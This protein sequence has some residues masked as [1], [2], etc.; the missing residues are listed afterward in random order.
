MNQ[1]DKF[2][3]IAQNMDG[4]SIEQGLADGNGLALAINAE[5]GLMAMAYA[6]HEQANPKQALEILLDDMQLNLP[7]SENRD[8]NTDTVLATQCL[9]ESYENINEFLLDT[10]AR[11]G[12]S[13][14]LRPVAL[15]AIQFVNDK[16]SCAVVGDFCCLKF[17]DERINTLN[18]IYEVNLKG[19]S[20]LG[21]KSDFRVNM[22]QHGVKAGDFI[23]LTTL[24]VIHAV[25]EEHIRL[26]L[27][28]FHDNL[29]MALRQINTRAAKRGLEQKPAMI[30]ARAESPVVKKRGW[31]NKFR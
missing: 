14:Q 24:K 28:R 20:T 2:S 21:S 9:A 16:L 31:L 30:I 5:L 12:H 27:S 11:D 6:G 13:D 19:D 25:G 22:T 23:M 15:A 7:A 1:N 18:D 3:Y 10:F 17:S 26:T 8:V 4:Q 29:D